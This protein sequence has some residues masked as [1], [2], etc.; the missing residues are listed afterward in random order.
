LAAWQRI[1]AA[2]HS[3]GC[4]IVPQLWHVGSARHPGA[5]PDPSI[6]AFTPSGLTQDFQPLCHVMSEQDICDVIDTFAQAAADAR[7]IGFDGVEIHGAHG[8]LVDEFFWERTNHRSDRYGQSLENR[9]RFAAEIVQAVRRSVGPRFP[10]LFRWSQWKQQDYSARLVQNPHEL[11]RMLRPLSE[12][13]VDVF[14]CST[15]RYWQPEFEGSDL[16]LAGWTKKVT[17]KPTITVGSVGL[18]QDIFGKEHGRYQ[19]ARPA[20][21]DDL[22]RRLEAEEFDLVAVGR[23]LIADPDWARKVRDGAVDQLEAFEK[24]KLRVLY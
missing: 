22:I 9:S 3:E 2:V 18:D 8:Y 6:P 14:H 21:L 5:E 10:I 19:A 20:S 7:A 15:R 1:V 17:G 11:E 23:A 24:G 13:G 12:A 4:R 16:N